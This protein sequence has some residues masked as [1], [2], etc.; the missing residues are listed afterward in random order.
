MNT[1]CT[2]FDLDEI[3]KREDNNNSVEEECLRAEKNEALHR[4]INELD[5]KYK[6]VIEL[7]FFEGLTNVE[8]AEKMS[9]NE[10]SIRRYKAAALEIL[11]DKMKDYE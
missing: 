9:V 1:N 8:I 4:A 7:S 2:D 3:D 11:K 6:Q 10:K 5:D